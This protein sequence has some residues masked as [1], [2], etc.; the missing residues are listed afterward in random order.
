MARFGEFVAEIPAP[1]GMGTLQ[2]RDGGMGE[3]VICEPYALADAQDIT[4]YGGLR[5]YIADHGGR[6]YY[7]PPRQGVYKPNRR[8]HAVN[9]SVRC[10]SVSRAAN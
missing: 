7:G 9:R 2:L 5:R 1:L 10:R 4:A 3:R 8:D 6:E